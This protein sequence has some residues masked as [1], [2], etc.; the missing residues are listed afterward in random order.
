MTATAAYQEAFDY[1]RMAQEAKRE[2]EVLRDR[3]SQRR[4]AGPASPDQE[5]VWKREN[6]V[7]YAMY[8]EQRCNARLFQRRALRGGGGGESAPRPA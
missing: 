2:Q 7:L 6:S 5:L 4:A 1:A 8:L 3:L